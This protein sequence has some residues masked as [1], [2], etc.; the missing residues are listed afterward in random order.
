MQNRIWALLG[1]LMVSWTDFWLHLRMSI[2]LAIEVQP[3]VSFSNLTEDL[4]MWFVPTH[5]TPHPRQ[6]PL[7]PWVD[8]P[9]QRCGQAEGCAAVCSALRSFLKDTGWLKCT[10]TQNGSKAETVWNVRIFHLQKSS[11]AWRNFFVFP[12]CRI[13]FINNWCLFFL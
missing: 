13:L 7:T 1:Y 6:V 9:P 12:Q 8:H 5:V 3:L 2:L 4:G 11:L 10:D